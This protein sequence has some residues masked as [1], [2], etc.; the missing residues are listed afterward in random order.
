MFSKFYEDDKSKINFLYTK[1]VAERL[2]R[3]PTLEIQNNIDV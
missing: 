1:V 3:D 2:K